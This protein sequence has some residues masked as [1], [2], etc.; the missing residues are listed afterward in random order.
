MNLSNNELELIQRVVKVAKLVG[1]ESVIIEPGM[2]RG[3]DESRTV[4]INQSE[5]VPDLQ[6][7]SIGLSRLDVFQS[8]LDVVKGL[9][10]FTVEVET[11]DGTDYVY[12]LVM[13][14]KGTKI[15]FRCADPT[16]M[17]AP[18][19]M[20]DPL[21]VRVPISQTVVHMIQKGIAAIGTDQI[22]LIS[23]SEGVSFEMSDVNGDVFKHTFADAPELLADDH[24]GKFAFRYPA[25]IILAI[26]KENPEGSFE[27]GLKGVLRF[28]INDINIYVPPVV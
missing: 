25:K 22:A 16:K 11:K 17:R 26:F 8:R 21:K 24:Q 13:K 14:A 4:V 15:D 18:K 23:N 12:S 6:F 20:S 27:V 1:I 3:I 5:N 7:G 28:P 19:K 2:I 9:E 10:K